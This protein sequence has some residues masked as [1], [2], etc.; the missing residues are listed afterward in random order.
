[1]KNEAIEELKLARQQIGTLEDI[2]I[3]YRDAINQ[4]DA[5]FVEEYES[6]TDRYFVDGVLHSL[7][8]KLKHL[9]K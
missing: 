5:Y 3:L 2:N 9:Q 4:I 7:T 1:M 8:I 6:D